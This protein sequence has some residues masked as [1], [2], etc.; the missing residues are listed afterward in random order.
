MTVW[1][2]DDLTPWSAAK[3]THVQIRRRLHAM[4]DDDDD[5]GDDDDD[6]DALNVT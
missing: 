3:R 5:D 2:C 6:D 1:R 4:D